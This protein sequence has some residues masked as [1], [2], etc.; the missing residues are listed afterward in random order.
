ETPARL[1]FVL[2]DADYY[3]RFG[4]SAQLARPFASPYAGDAFMALWLCD[5]L[6]VPDAGVAH[7]APAFGRVGA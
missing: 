7:H 3:E 4:Y 2:G 1:A 6:S 5:T